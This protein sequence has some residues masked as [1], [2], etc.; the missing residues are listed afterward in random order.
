MSPKPVSKPRRPTV[1][2][3]RLIEAARTDSPK[4]D[5]P[6]P[7]TPKSGTPKSAMSD[8]QEECGYRGRK[9]G[10]PAD[11]IPGQDSLTRLGANHGFDVED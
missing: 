9:P 7:G 1:S 10:Q 3:S 8:W 6:E 2:L 11:G 4:S 5:S